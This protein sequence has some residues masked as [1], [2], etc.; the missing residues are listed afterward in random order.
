MLSPARQRTI[1]SAIHCTGV[2]LHIGKRVTL[3]LL[4]AETDRGIVFR[5]VDLDGAPEVHALWD[6]SV[7]SPLCTNLVEDHVVVGTIEHLMAAL[8]GMHID[9]VTVE[10]DGPEVPIMD[11]SA[12]P[13]VFLI[14]CAGAV[15]Q[16][17]PRRAI[18]VLKE[19]RVGDANRWAALK[20]GPLPSVAFE[21]D[22]PHPVI[23]KQ[24]YG[25]TLVNGTFKN[26]LSRA[27]T[28]GFLHEV[29]KLRANGLALG[30]SLD[31]A[32]VVD[33]ERI[34]NAEGLRYADEFVRHKIVDS[35]G[36]LYLAGGPILGR[37]EGHRSGH[38]LT[39]RLLRALMSDESAWEPATF[40]D[41]VLT[42]AW[43]AGPL[44]ATA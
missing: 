8:A 20:P 42:P 34:L 29:D 38:A 41:G 37:F 6:R 16:A 7:E 24:R 40:D 25:V 4:P 31:N 22:F 5:R 19:V 26:E 10:L 30:G 43:E 17:V 21:I 13:F 15:E 9:N 32:I 44:A 35:I 18:R 39:T 36:D 1:K 23:A 28:F 12:A 2:G 14:E 27:R 3:R 33:G 11:G